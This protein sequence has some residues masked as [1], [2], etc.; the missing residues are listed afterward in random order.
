MKIDVNDQSY[1]HYNPEL[2]QRQKIMPIL[3]IAVYQMD[4]ACQKTDLYDYVEYQGQLKT[5]SCQYQSE[6]SHRIPI[7]V[8][9]G[10]ITLRPFFNTLQPSRHTDE[11]RNTRKGD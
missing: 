1:G 8:D 2:Q 9:S 10:I 6:E 5:Y 11:F 3:E 4:S 7:P